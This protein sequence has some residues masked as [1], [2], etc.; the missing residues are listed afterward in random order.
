M[1][2]ALQIPRVTLSDSSARHVLLCLANYAGTDG[3]GAFPSA[4]TLSED[5][6]LSERTVRSKLELLRASE[7]IVP[8][9]Q[10]LAAVYIERHDRRPVVYDLPIKRGANPAPRTERGADDG[11]GCKSQQNGVQN[12]TERGAKFAPNTSLNHQLTEQQQPREI[13]DVI[14]DQDKQALE[15]TDDRQRFAMFADWA[16]DSRYLIAQAQIAGIKPADIPDALIRSFIGWFVAKQNTVDTSAG[17]CNRLV[18]WYV[19][20]RAKG[21]LSADEEAAVGGDW[22]SKGVIL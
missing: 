3:R 11:T 12:S 17:W 18:V 21:S 6:G 9:N 5:T 7:L 13:S 14:A 8:G 1:S 20:E 19:K 10:A 4:T 16:P 2:W 15:S 22:A